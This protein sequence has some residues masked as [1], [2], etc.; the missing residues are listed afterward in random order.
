LKKNGA[1]IT[2]GQTIPG[3]YPTSPDSAMGGS[4][5]G[6]PEGTLKTL[7]QS[8]ISGSQYVTDPTVLSY[9]LRGITYVELPAGTVWAG[10]TG[11]LVYGSGIVVVHNSAHNAAV[12]NLTGI[13]GSGTFVGIII[14]D[15]I[16]H[17]HSEVIGAIIEL[18]AYPSEGS[19]IGNSNGSL[20]FSRQAIADAINSFAG[21]TGN[22]SLGGVVGWWE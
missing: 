14:A 4:A 19:C 10:K 18:T 5:N 3:G 7:A 11:A 8:G 20:Y 21:S 9:P 12:K 15:D 17:L 13:S 2:Q 22:G 16:V 1:V 6:Y